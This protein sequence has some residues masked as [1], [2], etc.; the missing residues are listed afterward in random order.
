MSKWNENQKLSER[1]LSDEEIENEFPDISADDAEQL[2][3]DLITISK[4]LYNLFYD[5]KQYQ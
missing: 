1:K 5:Q 2:K 4:I 3:E